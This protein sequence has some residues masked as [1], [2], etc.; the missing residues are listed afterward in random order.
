MQFVI[1]LVTQLLFTIVFVTRIYIRMF[2]Q[3]SQPFLTQQLHSMLVFFKQYFIF[4]RMQ[5]L[6]LT[7]KLEN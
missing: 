5:I 4:N 6:I 1:K 2:A 3:P 7:Q